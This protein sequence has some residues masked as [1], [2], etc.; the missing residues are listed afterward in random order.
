MPP[1]GVLASTPMEPASHSVCGPSEVVGRLRPSSPVS[2][3]WPGVLRFRYV[4]SRSETPAWTCDNVRR[5][6]WATAH[7]SAMSSLSRVPTTAVGR[8]D[9]L[10]ARSY[11]G[12]HISREN[13]YSSGSQR[14]RQGSLGLH[15]YHR[16]LQEPD[17]LLGP[18]NQG[19]YPPKLGI[20]G[21]P[22]QRSVER[23]AD[24]SLLCGTVQAQERPHLRVWEREERGRMGRRVQESGSTKWG[25]R[26]LL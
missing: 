2:G 3:A 25:F 14:A 18:S 26:V 7:L 4:H 24:R 5:A 11:A 1:R 17:G 12:T 10:E 21:Q 13:H 6:C 8:S 9:M 23:A 20:C 19:R 15:V 16:A 22:I